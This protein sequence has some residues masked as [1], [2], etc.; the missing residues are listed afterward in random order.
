MKKAFLVF[1][2]VFS[3]ILMILGGLAALPLGAYN[4]WGGIGGVLVFI[5]GLLIYLQ[6]KKVRK[7]M[8]SKENPVNI[9]GGID[10]SAGSEETPETEA[11]EIKEVN[12][13]GNRKRQNIGI[14]I[15]V[16]IITL[17][18]ILIVLGI[19]FS[20]GNKTE[21]N[22]NEN[23]INYHI[24]S[25]KQYLPKRIAQAPMAF[26]T[27]VSY[28][29]SSKLVEYTYESI[30]TLT[31]NFL[32]SDQEK[33][34]IDM[35]LYQYE[36]FDINSENTRFMKAMLNEGVSL[37]NTFKLKN[38]DGSYSSAGSVDYP[39]ELNKKAWEMTQ[40]APEKARNLLLQHKLSSFNES[41]P[42]LIGVDNSNTSIS[43]AINPQTK[44]S[45]FLIRQIVPPSVD[46]DY[47]KE[48]GHDACKNEVKKGIYLLVFTKAYRMG[49]DYKFYKH[50][51]K[52][53]VLIHYPYD[54]ISHFAD[55]A[56]ED[57]HRIN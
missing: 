43:V 46:F 22:R 28:N 1:C 27:D 44:D 45:V 55:K 5:W 38:P 54:E 12:D 2:E 42:R 13:N 25:I 37:R 17:F 30:D 51:L 31:I 53:S 21:I 47:L 23:L 26:L 18:A 34:P 19:I 11:K 50:D 41:L 24:Q 33:N 29:Q 8:A 9:I 15:F 57:I 36:I 48:V 32:K 4:I 49:I 35:Y 20:G 16:G 14:Y 6:T 10:T 40:E 39:A 56:F 3:W 52:D 7:Q